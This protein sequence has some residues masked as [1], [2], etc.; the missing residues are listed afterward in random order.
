MLRA[1]NSP[2]PAAT[3]QRKIKGSPTFATMRQRK[4]VAEAVLAVLEFRR[5]EALRDLRS[6]IRSGRNW[7]Q[8][9]D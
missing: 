9:L 3:A 8:F 7:S 1:L 4:G 5:R 6:T 2:Q